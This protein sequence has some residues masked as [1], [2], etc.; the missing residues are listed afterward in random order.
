MLISVPM[1]STDM[2]MSSTMSEPPALEPGTVLSRSDQAHAHMKL[3]G[4]RTG[5]S[6][7][8]GF[9]CAPARPALHAGRLLNTIVSICCER[10]VAV[11]VLDILHDLF[12]QVVA[13]RRNPSRR[14]RLQHSRN[15][16]RVS[17]SRQQSGHRVR[18]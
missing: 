10:I 9:R 16:I 11:G 12:D 14:F 2:L 1:L 7:W 3:A 6:H 8:F 13:R 4:K 5:C 17:T 18:V 15:T